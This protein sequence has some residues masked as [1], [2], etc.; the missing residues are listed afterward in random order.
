VNH[1]WGDG[2]SRDD[3]GVYRMSVPE[4]PG[5]ILASAAGLLPGGI[6]VEAEAFDDF[7]GWVMDSQFEHEMG[8]PYLLA[9]GNG[10]PVAD[11]TTLVSV[12]EAGSYAVWVRAKDWVPAHHPG[13]FTLSVNGVT[14]DTEFGANGQDWSWQAAG[15]VELPAGDTRLVLHDLTGFAGRCDAIFFARDEL[16]PPE[17]GHDGARSWRKTLRGLPEEPVDA[18][19]FDVVVVGGGVTGA[20]AALAAARLGD[21]V[22]L[23]QDRP[24]LGGNASIEIGL[25]PRGMTGPLINEL[26]ERD[27]TGDLRALS[28]LRAEPTATVFMEHLV[29]DAVTEDS[30]ILS[31]DARESRTGREIRLSAPVFI[32]CSGTAALGLLSGAETMFGQEARSEYGEPLAPEERNTMHHGNTVFFRTRMVE[33]PVSFPDVPWATEVSKDFS[34]LSG[35][36][37]T[38]GFEN[39]PGPVV[40]HP[41]FIEDP[42]MNPRMK[43]PGTHFWEYGQWLDPYTNG[44]LV[45][46]HLWRALYG[47][48]SNVKTMEP[49]KWANLELDWVAFVPGQGEYKRYR[50]DYVL[51][52]NDV[53]GHAEFDDTVVQN[54]GAFCMHFPGDEN[55]KYDFRLKDWI[56]DVRDDLPY[57]IPF[58]TLY[59]VNISNLLV[60]GKHTSVTRIA[61]SNTKLMG[62]GGQHAIATAAAAHLCN[63]HGATPRGIL[64]S[65]LAELQAL[66]ATFTRVAA[67]V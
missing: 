62:N 55:D 4:V 11:A 19:S 29:F 26:A 45:R 10:V 27:E 31:V 18:G 61:G 49:E 64:E 57:N 3:E 24:V 15:S 32:D 8:S 23:I 56:W 12:A 16:T 41:G 66:A 40:V 43:F 34:D 42:N 13:R 39:G 54:F 5:E 14:L 63:K 58:R 36:L 65:H 38:P 60:A 22:A 20:A 17:P 28:L 30:T 52:E 35:Q 25:S 50:G 48:L 6:L 33:H 67:E 7:G 53:R 51:S 1:P 9:H 47:T 21:R 46:D 59:S 37:M 44:E 2:A